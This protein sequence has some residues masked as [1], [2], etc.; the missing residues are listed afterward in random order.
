MLV[1]FGFQEGINYFDGLQSCW[2]VENGSRADT[3]AA[4]AAATAAAT[5]AAA[6]Q[7]PNSEELWLRGGQLILI[8]SQKIESQLTYFTKVEIQKLKLKVMPS[9]TLF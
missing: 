7:L 8:A 5:T 2:T 4:P 3:E 6:Q 1:C 9:S